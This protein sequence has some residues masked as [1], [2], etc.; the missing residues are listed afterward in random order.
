MFM[1]RSWN[2]KVWESL[3]YRAIYCIQ[4]PR[5][6]DSILRNLGLFTLSF[7]PGFSLKLLI[8]SGGSE[9][10]NE[11][12]AV[13][14]LKI[15]GIVKQYDGLRKGDGGDEQKVVFKILV[16]FWMIIIR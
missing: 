7:I 12:S 1:K 10:E 5:F 15:S 4:D 8:V 13:R 14:K 11:V 2:L 6:L 16:D 9:K 3:T